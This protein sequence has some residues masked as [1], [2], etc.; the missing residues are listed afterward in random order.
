MNDWLR[1]NRRL[2]APAASCTAAQWFPA[3]RAT[4]VGPRCRV[5]PLGPT[6]GR[7]G[8]SAPA[9][10]CRRVGGRHSTIGELWC[11]ELPMLHHQQSVCFQGWLHM[12]HHVITASRGRVQNFAAALACLHR[13]DCGRTSLFHNAEDKTT[14][15]RRLVVLLSMRHPVHSI[16]RQVHSGFQLTNSCAP[17]MMCVYCSCVVSSHASL[18][19]G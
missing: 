18:S 4:A 9:P 17:F 10:H 6:G 19:S 3:R 14:L 15:Q 2:R 7:V 13:L 8:V 12:L 11:H 16:R 5:A 1:E